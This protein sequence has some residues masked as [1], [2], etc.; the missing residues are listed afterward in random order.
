MKKF[1]IVLAFMLAYAGYTHSQMIEDF[2]HIPLNIMFGGE[3]DNSA[4]TVIGNPDLDEANPSQYVIEFFR[5][6]HGV[7]WGG[8]WSLLPEPVDMTNM[9]YVHVQVWKPRISPIRFKVEGGPGGTYEFESLEPQTLT[10]A[11]ET[12]TFY[13]PY[14]DGEYPVIVFMPDFEDPLVLVEDI[15]IY[16]D[17]IIFSDNEEP[18]EGNELMI[19]NFSPIPMNLMAGGEDDDSYFDVVFNPYQNEANPSHRVGKFFRS[20]H[21]LPWGGFWS[22]IPEPFDMSEHKYVYVDVWKSRI[23]PVKFKVEGGPGGT[24]EFESMQPQTQVYEWETLVFHFPDADGEYPVI[25]FMPDFEDPLELDEDIIIYF[26]N[27]RLGG[28][29]NVFEVTFHVDIADAVMNGQLYGFDPDEHHILISGS[30]LGWAEPGTD[31]DQVME[32]HA[33]N[34]MVY[35]AT[36]QLEAGTYEYKYFSDLIGEGWDGG[37]WA[38]DPNRVVEV[39][40]HMVV[41]DVFEAGDPPTFTVTFDI[42]DNEGEPI[43]NATIMFNSII[44]EMGDY[45]FT[46]ITAG[47]YE[48]IINAPGFIEVSD[49]AEV[50]E[51]MMIEVVMEEETE[52]NVI[53]TEDISLKIYPNPVRGNL[54]IEADSEIKSVQ[55]VDMLG[56]VVYSSVVNNLIYEMN[57][58]GLTD[59]IYL[60]Q[61]MTQNGLITHRIQ[62]AK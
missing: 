51:E 61:I 7:P 50:T 22:A 46:D 8:F 2:E 43:E 6:K 12:I 11:W 55:M 26:D 58:S 33:D 15:I 45:T 29:P 13:F 18:G 27:I 24:F 4:M 3:N 30:L 17:N 35:V 19:E 54:Y 21:G 47:I 53:E 1:M 5:S 9:K 36:F 60:V 57:I 39:T 49:E 10:E 20:Q 14:A 40:N 32:P 62:V 59:G 28:E 31:P 44:N 42:I 25:A 48:Y 37:E 38:G 16:F 56:Q 34:P 23:S 41:E 52:P